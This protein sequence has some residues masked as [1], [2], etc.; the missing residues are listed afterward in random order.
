MSSNGGWDD[1]SRVCWRDS[2][3]VTERERDLEKDDREV[4]GVTERGGDGGCF[5]NLRW[6]TDSFNGRTS[7]S[8]LDNTGELLRERMGAGPGGEQSCEAS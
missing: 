3:V 1:G 7:G 4:D 5:F 2:A 6:T 8:T